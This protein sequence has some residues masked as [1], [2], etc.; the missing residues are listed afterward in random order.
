M[1]AEKATRLQEAASADPSVLLS[2]PSPP[3]RHEIWKRARTRPS[4]DFTSEHSRDVAQRIVSK[5]TT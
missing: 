1:V 2:P 5:L 4:G 3:K